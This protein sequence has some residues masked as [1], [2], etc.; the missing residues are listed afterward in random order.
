MKQILQAEKE[1]IHGNSRTC[2]VARPKR[3]NAKVRADTGEDGDDSNDDVF[4]SGP[5]VVD[6]SEEEL[7]EEMDIL[8][9]NKE[10]CTGKLLTFYCLNINTD[11]F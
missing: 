7:D 1:D 9:S 11:Y 2:T 4:T 10:V 6:T 3:L 8:I 5:E